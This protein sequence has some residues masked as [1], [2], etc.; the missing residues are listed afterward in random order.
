M[1]MAI[2][3][4]LL[5]QRNYFKNDDL[6]STIYFGGGTPSLLSGDEIASIITIIKDEFRVELQAEITLEGNPDDLTLGK[7][8][9]LRNCG[10]NRLSIGIQSFDNGILEFLNRPHSSADAI[11]SVTDARLAGFEN[12]S[13]DLIYSIP[14][15]SRDTWKKN[16]DE[17][18]GLKPEHI[19]AY[20]LTI[21][22]KT[23]FGNRYLKGSLKPVEDDES[24]SQ[25]EMLVLEL[26]DAGYEQYEVSNFCRPARHSK[27]NSSY[28]TQQKY[29]GIGP[30]AHS[31]NGEIRQF[32]ISN[33]ALYT[34]AIEEGKIPFEHE[35]LSRADRIN[36]YLL[37]TLR[38][39]WGAN[40][41]EMRKIFDYNLFDEQ[42]IYIQGLLDNKLA[43]LEG[44]VLTLTRTGKMLADKITSD[45]FLE[46]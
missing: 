15:Q 45:L 31:Y 18:I 40:L 24:A 25:L 44:D 34:R 13:I 41:T 14:G 5:L 46:I 7:L 30:S 38:T 17:A 2:R 33:N 19:S 28:W 39:R 8:N 9:D 36:E 23:T 6:V 26:E 29:L 22:N 32:N 35:T 10:V 1:L 4:E 11:K 12:L 3:N 43:V 20:S 21:E 16:I 42:Q 27:H 37:T